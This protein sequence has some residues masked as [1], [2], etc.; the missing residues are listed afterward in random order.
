MDVVYIYLCVTTLSCLVYGTTC[1][2]NTCLLSVSFTALQEQW[3]FV[4]LNILYY[5][6]LKTKIKKCHTTDTFF[7]RV[8]IQV[9]TLHPPD[10]R[11]YSAWLP[12]LRSLVRVS[13]GSHTL[14]GLVAK[15]KCVALWMAVYGTSV[16]ERPLKTIREEKGV[17]S[18]FRV[19]VAI[20]CWNRCKKHIPS[21]PSKRVLQRAYTISGKN[22]IT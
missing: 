21:I 8:T 11:G 3:A 5:T 19:L 13:A 2:I 12:T 15:C 17:Y 6:I 1:N 18:H 4:N 10:P 20:G 16:T 22:S 7:L 9:C 14:V